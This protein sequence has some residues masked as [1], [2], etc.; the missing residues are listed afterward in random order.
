MYI[1]TFSERERDVLELNA[2]HSDTYSTHLNDLSLKYITC[3][4][5]VARLN[6]LR[7]TMRDEVIKSWSDGRRI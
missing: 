3:R 7:P 2:Q 6:I 4:F 1:S 5:A